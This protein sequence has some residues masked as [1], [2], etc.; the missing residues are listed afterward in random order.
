MTEEHK[1]K[2]LGGCT[3]KGFLPGKSGN[4][5][6]RP[7]RKWLTEV[8]EELLDEKL[9]DPDFRAQYKE[10][11]W[12]K[13]LAKGVVSAMTLDKVWER[14]EGKVS[15]PVEMNGNI[16]ISTI[17]EKIAKARERKNRNG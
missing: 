8:T 4:P 9:Q 17:S 15:Q 1:E 16:N 5:G 14:T 12:N 3:G 6:G 2:K 10:H 11:L 13:L 7:R